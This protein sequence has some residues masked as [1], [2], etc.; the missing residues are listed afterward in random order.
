MKVAG[1]AKRIYADIG[2]V[3]PMGFTQNGKSYFGFVR[4]NFYTSI[5]PFNIETGEIEMGSGKSLKGSNY[6]LTWSLD[7]QYLAYIK[8]Q[9]GHANNPVQFI[10]QDLKTGEEKK[11]SNKSFFPAEYSWSPDGKSI[12]VA[13]ME[14]NQF[15]GR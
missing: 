8:I 15:R 1:P 13:G 10:V 6:G 4:R 5:A 7:G 14:E 9:D 3:A 11:P 12:L 2:E